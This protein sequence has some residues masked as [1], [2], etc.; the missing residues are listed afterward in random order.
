MVVMMREGEV[1]FT[2][3]GEEVKLAESEL[4]GDT[5]LVTFLIE[6][7]AAVVLCSLNGGR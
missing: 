6:P 5:R 1:R 2:V 7:T 3:N 4:G